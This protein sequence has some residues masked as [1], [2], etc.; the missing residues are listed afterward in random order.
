MNVRV[1]FVAL[2]LLALPANNAAAEW[3][4]KPIRLLAPF[5]A[6]GAADVIARLFADALSARFGQPFVVE[7]RS[8][9]GGLVGAQSIVHATPGGYTL[10]VAGMSSHV[11]APAGSKTPGFD[12]IGDFTHI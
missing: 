10:M 4:E 2:M 12:P 6:G 11:L 7:N 1:A 9:G 5:A 3:P 8:G